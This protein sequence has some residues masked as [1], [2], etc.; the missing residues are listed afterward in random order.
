MGQ[1]SKCFG[2]FQFIFT[3]NALLIIARRK[4][5]FSTWSYVYAA[6]FGDLMCRT[7]FLTWFSC[8]FVTLKMFLFI[9]HP[10]IYHQTREVLV[11]V[12]GGFKQHFFQCL[13]DLYLISMSECCAKKNRKL[14]N[15]ESWEFWGQAEQRGPQMSWAGLRLKPAKVCHYFFKE[16]FIL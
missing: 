8:L 5:C 4:L 14:H 3:W 2:F 6:H 1:Q 13:W 16:T 12:V 10:S 15:D 7:F 11:W 9:F